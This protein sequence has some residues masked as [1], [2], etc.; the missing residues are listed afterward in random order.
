MQVRVALFGGARVVTGQA[1][2]DLSFDES[3]VTLGRVI[4]ALV[5]RYPRARSYLLDDSGDI[6]QHIRALLNQQ[7]PEPDASLAALIHDGDHVALLVAVAG[8]CLVSS[9]SINRPL[10]TFFS[11]PIVHQ[12]YGTIATYNRRETTLPAQ[13]SI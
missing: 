12:R 1:S 13:R 11:F 10:R 4:E 9:K 5:A 6:P 3:P 2:V 7:R 8:G